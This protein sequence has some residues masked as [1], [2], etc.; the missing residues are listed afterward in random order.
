MSENLSWLKNK[1][2]LFAEDDAVLRTQTA[3][4]LEMLFGTVYP[5]ED[6]EEAYRV[7]EDEAPDI[8]ITDIKMPKKDGLKLVDQ[9][10]RNDY[11]TPIILLSRFTESEMLISAANL[12]VDGYLIKPMEVK[13]LTAAIRKSMR[14]SQ[15]ES[16][17]VKLGH[18]LFFDMA[19]QELY[20]NGVAVSLGGKELDLLL[21][22]MKQRHKT[23]T[24]DEISRALWPLD[25]ICDSAI[26]NLIL[27]IRKKLNAEIIVSVRGIGYRLDTREYS[28][29]ISSSRSN[30]R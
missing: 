16:E 1:S 4:V 24:K 23:V 11:H 12:S 6:G 7:Y 30:D 27:R 17:S 8:I 26:K 20:Q 28:T 18:D 14:R 13:T 2:V 22:L 9:I 10:R 19:T 3:E 29:G 15:R 21:L 25:P 5:V